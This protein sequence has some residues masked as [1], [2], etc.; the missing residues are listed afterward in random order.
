MRELVMV[1]LMDE[2]YTGIYSLVTDA[3]VISLFINNAVQMPSVP[4]MPAEWQDDGTIKILIT[5]HSQGERA[6]DLTLIVTPEQKFTLTH[7]LTTE[8]TH[9]EVALREDHHGFG[10]TDLSDGL[11]GVPNPPV[12]D[13]T[14]LRKILCALLYRSAIN[15]LR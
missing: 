15:Q 4:L 1:D 10:V 14:V 13:R 11:G 2:R 7:D 8:L 6:S 9:Y 12:V 5:I 3:Q